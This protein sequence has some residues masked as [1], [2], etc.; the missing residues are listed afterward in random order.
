[1][2]RRLRASNTSHVGAGSEEA[3]HNRTDPAT[4]MD[5]NDDG[6][7]AGQHGA[8]SA[9]AA[10]AAATSIFIIEYHVTSLR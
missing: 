6:G 4:S 5:E 2:T 3:I 8:T 9:A 1:M 10:A 7:D